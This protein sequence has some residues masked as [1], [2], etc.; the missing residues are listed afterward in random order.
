VGRRAGRSEGERGGLDEQRATC[1]GGQHSGERPARATSDVRRRTAK[2]DRREATGDDEQRRVKDER[3]ASDDGA[4]RRREASAARR[5]V[6]TSMSSN[7]VGVAAAVAFAAPSARSHLGNNGPT[8]R[9]AATTARVVRIGRIAVVVLLRRGRVAA[10]HTLHASGGTPTPRAG[11]APREP[12]ARQR[13]DFGRLDPVR[14]G[15]P[16]RGGGDR[17]RRRALG[18]VWARERLVAAAAAADERTGVVPG[19]RAV[20]VVEE[21]RWRA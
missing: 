12:H 20:V 13:G 8:P 15:G 11:R 16:A 19:A 6:A 4:A 10:T 14:A 9:G 17:A 3:V 5:P 21:G 1:D 2:S 18:L 7:S